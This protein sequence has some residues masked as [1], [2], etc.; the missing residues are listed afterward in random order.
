ML[1]FSRKKIFPYDKNNNNFIYESHNP[2]EI[3]HSIIIMDEDDVKSFAL[4]LT[5]EGGIKLFPQGET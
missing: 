1:Y 3:I 4:A 5:C 2:R